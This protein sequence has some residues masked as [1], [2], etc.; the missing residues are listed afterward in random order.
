[1]SDKILT[2]PMRCQTCAESPTPGWMQMPGHD[3]EPCDACNAPQED[4][5]TASL[6]ARCEKAERER[7]VALA[8][9]EE[10]RSNPD[11]ELLEAQRDR[12]RLGAELGEMQDELARLAE[13]EGRKEWGVSWF[14]C[15]F[16]PYA[17]AS[18]DEARKFAADKNQ[19]TLHVRRAAIAPGPWEPVKR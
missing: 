10:I 14:G 17:R 7:D 2:M 16:G 18:E 19:A 9:L 12:R 6:K 1:M 8:K 11:I 3:G 5:Y 4:A 15:R 13:I